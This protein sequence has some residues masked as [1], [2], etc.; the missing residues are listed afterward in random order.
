MSGLFASWENRALEASVPPADSALVA[1]GLTFAYADTTVISDVNIAVRSG[2]IVAIMGPSGSG[3]STLLH[4]LAGLFVPGRGQVWH[5]S[6]RVDSLGNRARAKQRLANVGFV[7]QFGDLIPELNV[8]ENTE[9]PL[10]LQ[11]MRPGLARQRAMAML[12]SLGLASLAKKRLFEVSG[13]QAQL[14]AVARS[15]VHQPGL[16]L[17]DEPTGA[18]NTQD[19]ELVLEALLR[20]AQ[21][22]GAAVVVVTHAMRVAAWA[23]RDIQLLDGRR[24]E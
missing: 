7:F 21:D 8:V 17:A 18:L 13:G 12:D 16:V 22:H 6:T 23:D 1:K 19:G 3:K 20:V 4:L 15:V 14:V 5:G 9:F 10:R 2:D 24:V 11:G